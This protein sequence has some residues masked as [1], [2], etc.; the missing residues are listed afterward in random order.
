MNILVI[1]HDLKFSGFLRDA[2]KTWN[3]EADFYKQGKGAIKKDGLKK[4]NLVILDISRDDFE[5]ERMVAKVK[6]TYPDSGIIIFTDHN[7]RDLE[8]RIRKHGILYYMIKP[9]EIKELKNLIDYIER[10]NIKKNQ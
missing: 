4:Y 6:E 7:S 8:I 3:L 5:G 10:K 2:L 1:E 9:I